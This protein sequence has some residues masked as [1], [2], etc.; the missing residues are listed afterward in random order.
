MVAVQ[1]SAACS[2]REQTA[3]QA[4]VSSAPSVLL[5]LPGQPESSK[6]ATVIRYGL[7]CTAKLR[8]FLSQN[9][10]CFYLIIRISAEMCMLAV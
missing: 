6:Y 9:L 3:P 10:A 2:H 8:L 7:I 5:H 1:N 4:G